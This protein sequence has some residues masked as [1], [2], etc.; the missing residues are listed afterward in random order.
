MRRRTKSNDGSRKPSYLRDI[1]KLRH[2]LVVRMGEYY[3]LLV[4]GSGTKKVGFFPRVLS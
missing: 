1:S 4:M 2:W 3:S